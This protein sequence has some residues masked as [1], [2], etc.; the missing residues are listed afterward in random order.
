M[1]TFVKKTCPRHGLTDYYSYSSGKTK[2][3]R[4][5][6]DAVTA[7]R[8][9]VTRILKEEHGA[10]CGVCGYDRCLAALDF[11]HRDPTKKELGIGTGNTPG[12]ARLRLEARKCLLVC[13]NCHR[14]IHAGLHPEYLDL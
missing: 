11:H 6:I 4:C 7:R 8:R 1:A 13:A 12:I 9:N 5:G 10:R 3:K 2:C 14:E